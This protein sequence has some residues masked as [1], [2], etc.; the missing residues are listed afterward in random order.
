MIQ[1]TTKLHTTGQTTRLQK[2][3]NIAY[4]IRIYLAIGILTITTVALAVTIILLQWSA[5]PGAHLQPILIVSTPTPVHTPATTATPLA[6][7]PTTGTQ[8]NAA[9]VAYDA[10]GGNVLGSLD[11]QRNYTITARYGIDWLQAEVEGS[12][13]VW[14]RSNELEIVT[15][16]ATLPDLR[17]APTAAIVYVVQEHTRTT[18]ASDSTTAAQPTAPP[19]AVEGPIYEKPTPVLTEAEQFW[20]FPTAQPLPRT[21]GV[22]VSSTAYEACRRS[23]KAF[24]ECVQHMPDDYWVPPAATP[25]R[26]IETVQ[27]ADTNDTDT[28]LVP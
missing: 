1:N 6:P 19:N 5:P 27:R 4:E 14:V 18:T 21:P 3:Y 16:A 8:L 15:V 28:V 23:G 10:P 9:V 12:G 26:T 17:P 13:L 22:E 11:A 2:L 24:G 25:T 20:K 7:T